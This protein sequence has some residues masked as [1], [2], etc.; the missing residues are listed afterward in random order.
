MQPG[1]FHYERGA[2]VSNYIGYPYI[3]FGVIH[4]IYNVFRKKVIQ[5]N[6]SSDSL[7]CP[8]C[9]RIYLLK[10]EEIPV[11]SVCMHKLI[12]PKKYLNQLESKGLLNRKPQDKKLNQ[13][14]RINIDLYSKK[15]IVIIAVLYLFIMIYFMLKGNKYL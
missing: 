3:I 8:H 7:V 4:I 15:S 2:K 11:C 9:N 12:S 5:E 14:K 10:T 6:K 1:E 13:F